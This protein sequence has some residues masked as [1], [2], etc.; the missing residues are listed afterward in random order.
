MYHK[1]LVPLDGSKQAETALS[2]AGKLA[3]IYNAEITLLRVVEYPFD[4]YARCDSNTLVNPSLVDEKLQIEKE[5][6]CKEV[7][8]YLKRLVEVTEIPVSKVSIEVRESPVVEA[9]L[10]T[11][12]NLEIDL[13]VMST[14]GQGRS[15][16]MIG[17]VA[18]RILRESPVPVILIGKESYASLPDRSS[19]QSVSRQNEVMM[20]S[21]ALLYRSFESTF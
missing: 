2:L 18:N 21:E 9:I 19:Q 7:E 8:D 1:I 3:R 10:S 12:E 6:V 4:M 5:F 11:A 15:P 17:A 20:Q 14:V 16:W 13:I